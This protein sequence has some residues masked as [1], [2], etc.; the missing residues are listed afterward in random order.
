MP[1]FETHIAVDW[2]ARSKPGP[3]KPARDSIWWAAVREGRALEPQYARTR[4]AAVERLAAF[5]GCEL[6]AGRRVLAG[7]DFPFGYPAG[8]AERLTGRACAAALRG[9]LA[10]QVED[11]P[12]NR[13]NRYAAAQKMSGYWPGVGPFWGRP[14]KW[15]YP[16]IPTRGKARTCRALH[17]CER[18]IADK[19]AKGAKTVWQLAYAGSVGSQV[20]VGLPALKRLL[21]HSCIGN[22]GR[23]WPFDTGLRAP[24]TG[25]A[26]LVLAEIYPSLL[27]KE[28]KERQ[29]GD[30]IPD[31]AQ[32]R[33]NAA[34]FARLDREDR[35]APLFA[36]ACGLD[37]NERRAVEREEAWILGLGHEEALRGAAGTECDEQG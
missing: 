14:A 20:L 16:G 24:D 12:D 9:W 34:A 22:R 25:E 36:G 15:D 28:V 11:K 7:F 29:G 8:V 2:S 32:V 5:I 26:R 31:R 4:H 19:R 18:R 35:L 27:R 10:E 21:D 33:V 17:P 23:V 6:D 13:N 30:K 37:A 3:A 1:L